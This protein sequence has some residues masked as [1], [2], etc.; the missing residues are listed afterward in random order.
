MAKLARSTPTDLGP[1]TRLAPSPYVVSVAHGDT[2]VLLHPLTGRYF[3]LNETGSVVWT[4]LCDNEPLAA[5]TSRI[6]GKYAVEEYVAS[7]D[8]IAVARCLLQAE[9]VSMVARD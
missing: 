1:S 4:A 3:T 5:A 2:L 9:L 8:V 6:R 7:T